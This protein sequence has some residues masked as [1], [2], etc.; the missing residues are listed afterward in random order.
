VLE[1]A[2]GLLLP[3]RF[4]TLLLLLLL[5]RMLILK[6]LMVLVVAVVATVLVA[7]ATVA[8]LVLVVAV[9][10]V[11]VLGG[12]VAT[13]LVPLYLLL[14]NQAGPCAAPAQLVTQALLLMTLLV[15][16]P[17]PA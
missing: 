12:V 17:I 4:V 7:L 3:C 11:L 15:C 9:L 5:I 16:Q 2:A 10:A 1:Q 13:A 8:A 6:V 14:R